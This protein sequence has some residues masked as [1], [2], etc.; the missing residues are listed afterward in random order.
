MGNCLGSQAS[1][2][3]DKPTV[4]IIGAG[5]GGL[6]CARQFVKNDATKDFNIILVEKSE[7]FTIGGMWQFVWN[8]RLTLKETKFPLKKA[9][10]P[11]IDLRTKTTVSKWLPQEKKV[12]LSNKKEIVY[13]HIVLSPGV[14]ADPKDVPGIENH[15]NICSIDHAARQKK[16]LEDL[17]AKAKTDKVTF[18]LTISVN[19]YKC[20]PAPFELVLLADE[21]FRKA[22][23]RDNVRV[24]R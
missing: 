14:V 16:D 2:S 1:P 17:V 22:G 10:L 9:I 11:G 24:G 7:H 8:S 12:V 23:V 5:F 19:P 4:L 13:E 6:G 21:Y 15:V 20:P 18:C 3:S